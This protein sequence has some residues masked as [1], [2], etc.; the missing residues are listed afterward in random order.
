MTTGSVN[1]STLKWLWLSAAIVGLD[2]ASKRLAID[3]LEFQHA[4]P[5]LPG[6]NLTLV[7][8]TGAA[9]SFLRDAGGWQRW[10]FIGLSAT[11]GLVIVIWLVRLPA[12]RRRLACALCL[13]LGGAAGNLWDRINLGYV[14]DFVDVYVGTWHWPAFNVADSA[15][16]LGAIILIV[17]ALWLDRAEV[18]VSSES[19][20][21]G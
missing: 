5:V 19:H 9:F 10:F 3:D 21:R 20:H 11:I 13:I 17:D 6:V 4:L 8:N 15:I 2:Q 1:L 16:S 14:I 18:S 12:E 7:H